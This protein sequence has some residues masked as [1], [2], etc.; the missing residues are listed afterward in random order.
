M[1]KLESEKKEKKKEK[2]KNKYLSPVWISGVCVC[3][4]GGGGG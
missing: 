4:G 1:D 2:K 3:F